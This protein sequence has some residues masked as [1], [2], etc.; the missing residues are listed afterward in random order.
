MKSQFPEADVNIILDLLYNNDKNVQKV[1]E[2]LISMGF[3]RKAK[4]VPKIVVKE[5]INET[6]KMLKS[7]IKSRLKTFEEKSKSKNTPLMA[8]FT[9]PT[10]TYP[11][12]RI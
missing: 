1:S 7:K 11:S 9:K 3:K 10:V 2:D 6:D 4:T 8:S 12:D 5:V